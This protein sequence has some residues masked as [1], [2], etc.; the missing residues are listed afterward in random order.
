[1][2]S[3]KNARQG[4][5]KN[6]VERKP[7]HLWPGENFRVPMVPGVVPPFDSMAPS[8]LSVLIGDSR[9]QFRKLKSKIGSSGS[10]ALKI[11]KEEEKDEKR[12]IK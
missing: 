5:S 3:R 7:G 1:M 6:S 8:I 11:M 2:V 4:A 9:A 12:K 10:N